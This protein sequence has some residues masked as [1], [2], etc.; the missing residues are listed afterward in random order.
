MG[1]GA[2]G[3]KRWSIASHHDEVND[4]GGRKARGGGRFFVV[5]YQRECVV[6]RDVKISSCFLTL[7][8]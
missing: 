7:M 5:L 2:R 6:S 4:G 3:V 8:D 1:S